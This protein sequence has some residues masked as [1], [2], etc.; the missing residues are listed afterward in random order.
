MLYR[1]T[2]VMPT[3]PDTAFFSGFASSM[4]ELKKIAYHLYN[5]GYEV[6]LQ[7]LEI[8][9]SICHQIAFDN[10]LWD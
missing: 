2:F 1:L 10:I 5:R 9:H 4:Q 7:V 6:Q 8:D 3:L